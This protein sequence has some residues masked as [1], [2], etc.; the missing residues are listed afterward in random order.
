MDALARAKVQGH[1]AAVIFVVQREDV[2]AFSP[3]DEADPIFGR[4]LREVQAAGVEVYAYRCRVS[5]EEV[6]L[7]C[8]RVHEEEAAGHLRS[9]I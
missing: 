8:L 1:R 3:N 6:G 5:P 7:P 4:A 2:Q 9:A